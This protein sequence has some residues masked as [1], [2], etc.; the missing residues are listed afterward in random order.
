MKHDFAFSGLIRC[1]H[2]GCALVGEIKKGQYTYY[3]CTGYKM[4]CPEPYVR[5]EV[6]AAE[7]RKIL[8]G[9]QFDEEILA[10]VKRALQES[11]NDL[12]MANC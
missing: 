7:F 9:L 10:W 5:E 11:H 3:H 6:L 1:G 2:C 4:K 12:A 8:S